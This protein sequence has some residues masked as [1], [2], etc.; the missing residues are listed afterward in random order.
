MQ[1]VE[2]GPHSFFKQ[3]KEQTTSGINTTFYRHVSKQRQTGLVVYSWQNLGFKIKALTTSN[4]TMIDPISGRV[5][6]RYDEEVRFKP[7]R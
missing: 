5:I 1:Y 7:H 3:K 6:P 4:F 2:R